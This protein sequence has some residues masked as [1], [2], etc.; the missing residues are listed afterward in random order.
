[1]KLH[2]IPFQDVPQF[3]YKDVSYTNAL[4]SLSPFYKYPVN[5]AA[6]EQ[7]MKDKAAKPVNRVVLN[8]VLIEQYAPLSKEEKVIHNI[9]A[10]KEENTFTLITAHQP[11][12]FTGPL[13]YIYKIISCI[14][15][16][17]QLKEQYPEKH[18]VPVFVTGGE[19]HDFEEVNYINLFNKKLV[20]E[21][22][23]QG[24]VGMMSTKNLA[25]TLAELKELLGT[26]EN[27][28]EIYQLIEKAYTENTIYSKATVELVHELFKAY[29]L[30][31]LNMNHPKLKQLFIPYIKE[32]ILKRPSKALVKETSQQ[33]EEVANFK[34]QAFPRPINFFYLRKNLRERIVFK[35]GMYEV[36]NTD[37]RFTE[38]EMIQEIEQHPEYFSPN[39]VMRPVYQE[40]VMPNLAYIGGGGELAYWL[41]RKTQFEHFEINFPMLIRRNSV[42]WLDK[43]TVKKVNKLDLSIP[44]IF[45]DQDSL[46]RLFVENQAETS[47]EIKEEKEAVNQAFDQVAAK[48]KKIDPTLAKAVLSEK[49]KQLKVLDQLESRLLRSEKQKYETSLNQIAGLKDK[50]FPK[51]GLQ[52][53]SDNFL[54]L[55][56][57]YGRSFFEVLLEHLDPMKKQFLVIEDG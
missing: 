38:A 9:Q 5:L 40:V 21:N 24:S 57:K 37:Y 15:L 8:E 36:L 27:A 11:S 53:R 42:L 51:N 26:S 29:G 18:F 50:L 23:E 16:S 10:L 28:V 52:E 49:S 55:Y 4:A 48:A 25:P 13:Y 17:R 33:L 22:E 14:H 43:G 3:S 39:V 35:K 19:D 34:Q 2:W 56:V 20:W 31:V 46:V 47:L 54:S 6:F 30:V 12:L 45:Q 32:E 44:Q 41:E 1:M 7:V